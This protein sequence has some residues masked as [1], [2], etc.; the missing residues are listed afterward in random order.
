VSTLRVLDA[1]NLCI[2]GRAFCLSLCDRP[3]NPKQG[4]VQRD[5]HGRITIQQIA[6]PQFGLGRSPAL[7]IN[8]KLLGQEQRCNPSG[9]ASRTEAVFVGRL[10][11]RKQLRIDPC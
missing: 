3:A 7:P 2:V 6:P 1:S 8:L 9:Q 11:R 5:C 4:G 10:G